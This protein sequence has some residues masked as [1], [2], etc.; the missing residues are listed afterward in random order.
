MIWNH[1]EQG[2][3]SQ[4]FRIL[5]ARLRYAALYSAAGVPLPTHTHMHAP[6]HLCG[7]TVSSQNHRRGKYVLGKLSVK[8]NGTN[9]AAL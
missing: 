3:F 5:P 4:L 9:S 8:K 1:S 6:S 7:A 2:L